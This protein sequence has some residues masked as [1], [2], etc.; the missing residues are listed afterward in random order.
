MWCRGRAA[1]RTCGT[2]SSR[3]VGRA[4]RARRTASPPRPVSGSTGHRVAPALEP[5]AGRHGG[6]A[7]PR[8]GALPPRS[9]RRHPGVTPVSSH[10]RV[11]R[12]SEGSRGRRAGRRTV[13]ARRPGAGRPARGGRS[14]RSRRCRRRRDGTRRRR[15]R[16]RPRA[17][18][19]PP[20]P[21]TWRFGE[22]QL[23]GRG[24]R[25]Q[26]HPVVVGVGHTE[27][28]RRERGLLLAGRAVA[29]DDVVH[30]VGHE[31]RRVVGVLDP[32][33]RGP[34]VG[35]TRRTRTRACLPE[36]RAGRGAGRR[37]RGRV[38]RATRRYWSTSD[39]SAQWGRASSENRGS[40][41]GRGRRPRARCAREMQAGAVFAHLRRRS[42]RRG[43]PARAC[44]G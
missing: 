28:H 14:R 24:A 5:L 21:R 40:R 37:A 6:F 26:Q 22:A 42:G 20:C 34:G 18:T 41:R 3:A 23:V 39:G 4:T 8:L 11:R 17:R 12:A 29:R 43:R 30:V 38:R 10:A 36:G 27:D 13:R 2:T 19:R 32:G 9:P 44:G 33:A 16:P 31:E 25:E 15:A 7:R 1:A 35:R